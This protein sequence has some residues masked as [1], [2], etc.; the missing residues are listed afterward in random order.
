MKKSR[1]PIDSN[2]IVR[3]LHL[4]TLKYIFELAL[5]DPAETEEGTLIN[6]QKSISQSLASSSFAPFLTITRALRMAISSSKTF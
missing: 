6:I 4:H 3:Y 5:A 1:S 2:P